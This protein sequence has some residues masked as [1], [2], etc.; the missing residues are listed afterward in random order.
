M[1]EL[2]QKSNNAPKLYC[3]V[4]RDGL[5]AVVMEEVLDCKTLSDFL[6]EHHYDDVQWVSNELEAVGKKTV[7]EWVCME[8]SGNKTS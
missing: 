2:L 7:R 1:H 3:C 4:E 6:S 8:T 5:K